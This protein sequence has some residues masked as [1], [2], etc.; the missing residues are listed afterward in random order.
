[1][2]EVGLQFQQLSLKKSDLGG[3]KKTRVSTVKCRD[4]SCECENERVVFE[5]TFD[6]VAQRQACLFVKHLKKKRKKSKA[7]GKLYYY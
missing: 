7:C 3:E 2:N 6:L 5:K 4:H 1:M